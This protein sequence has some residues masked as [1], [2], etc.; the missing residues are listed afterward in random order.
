MKAFNLTLL[1]ILLFMF[2]FMSSELTIGMVMSWEF[3]I[4]VGVVIG[5]L[6]VPAS[7]LLVGLLETRPL[8]SRVVLR[9]LAAGYNIAATLLL[10]WHASTVNVVGGHPVAFAAADKV[11]S[12]VFAAFAA[13]NALKLFQRNADDVAKS[14]LDENLE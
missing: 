12:F 3:L 5:L 13:L 7:F 10:V 11:W 14:I 2:A 8:R 9:R 4:F 6:S 1:S